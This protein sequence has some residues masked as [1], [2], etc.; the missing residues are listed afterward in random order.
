MSS[1]A[2]PTA[3]LAPALAAVS[4]AVAL[5]TA[6]PLKSPVA[7]GPGKPDAGPERAVRAANLDGVRE[8]VR[9]FIRAWNRD[10]ADALAAL[11][12][13]DGDFVSPTGQTATGRSDITRLLTREHEE[14]FKGT[15]LSKTIHRIDFS[16]STAAEVTGVYEL[17]G[18]KALLGFTVSAAGTFT[19]T[20]KKQGGRW[21][22]ER[23]S[24]TRS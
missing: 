18:V 9:D 12:L 19:F 2:G 15:S 8:T 17:D 4:L 21:L 16:T 6:G 24:I 20:L 3:C 23:A 5:G 1:K 7:A 13:P 10:D 11:V 14:I 22:I